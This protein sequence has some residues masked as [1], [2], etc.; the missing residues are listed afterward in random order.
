[1]PAPRKARPG[2]HCRMIFVAAS[3]QSEW[4]DLNTLLPELALPSFPDWCSHL[5][6]IRFDIPPTLRSL[7]GTARELLAIQAGLHL[8]HALHLRGTV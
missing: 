6:A 3:R 7:G 2:V 8:L 1:M 5:L 4:L